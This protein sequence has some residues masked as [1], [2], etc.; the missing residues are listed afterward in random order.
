MEAHLYKI[1]TS[2]NATHRAFKSPQKRV[3]FSNKG[4]LGFGFYKS[5]IFDFISSEKSTI[6]MSK[7]AIKRTLPNSKYLGVIEVPDELVNRLFESNESLKKTGKE[8][9]SLIK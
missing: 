9:V 5:E 6:E 8:L 2:D 4:V 1:L 7:R 3:Y